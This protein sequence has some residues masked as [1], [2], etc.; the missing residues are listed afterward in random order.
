LM[1]LVS[2]CIFLS[3]VLSCLTN[4]SSLFLLITISS[5]SYESLSSACSSLLEWPWICF[6]FLFYSFFWG[7]PYHGS[8]PL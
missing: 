1:E 5:S 7:F 2:S 6:V 3:Q 8:L 4:S